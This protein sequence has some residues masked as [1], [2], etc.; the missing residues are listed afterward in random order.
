MAHTTPDATIEGEVV[1]IAELQNQ[2]ATVEDELMQ[3]ESFQQ[4]IN[5][6][7]AVNERMAQLRED[8]KAVLIPA[9]ER[10]EIDKKITRSW[11]SAT[12]IDGDDFSIDE[13]L[14]PQKYW[15]KV[16]D[17]KNIRSLYHLKGQV[18]KGVTHIKKYGLRLDFNKE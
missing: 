15:K 4:F 1:E 10:G 16:P 14:L 7:K 12:V 2:L 17:L 9:Y 5:L 8:A 11:G 13:V 18:P 6:T 3:L